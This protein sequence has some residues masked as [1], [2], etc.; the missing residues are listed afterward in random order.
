MRQS[1]EHDI[2]PL[3][4]DEAAPASIHEITTKKKKTKQ[5]TILIWKLKTNRSTRVLLTC[6]LVTWMTH[7]WQ[8]TWRHFCIATTGRS[9]EAGSK[10][11]MVSHPF[12]AWLLDL[13]LECAFRVAKGF[14][15]A[16]KL[17]I[18]FCQVELALRLDHI[19]VWWRLGGLTNSWGVQG[20]AMDLT[21][22]PI[23]NS[24]SDRSAFS[25]IFKEA[26][27]E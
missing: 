23:I 7:C 9:L 3:Q 19:V 26:P 20:S 10:P 21:G 13:W 1:L 18:L 27:V 11:W 6:S 17:R 24:H 14:F 15:F 5:K 4:I 16:H 2:A 8:K 25:V 12:G 22:G